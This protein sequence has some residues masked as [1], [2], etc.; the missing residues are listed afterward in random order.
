MSSVRDKVARMSDRRVAAPHPVQR[1][2]AKLTRRGRSDRGVM[3]AVRALTA[4]AI[5]SANLVGAAIVFVILVWVIPPDDQVG[6]AVVN[7]ILVAGYVLVAIPLGIVWAFRKLRPSRRWM[8]EDR[9]P[10][11]E[12]QLNL[13]QSPR[14]VFVVVVGSLWLLAALV[15]GVVNTFESFELGRRVVVAIVLAGLATCQIAYLLTEWLLRPLAA[16]ALAARPLEDPALPGVTARTLI[17]WGLGS[18]VP[19]VGL[20]FVGL[21]VLIDGDMSRDQLAMAVL[22]LTAIALL[23]GFVATLIAARV[24]ADPIISVAMPSQTSPEATLTR[25]FP[26]TTAASSAFCRA[27]STRWSRVCA[28]ASACATSSVATSVRTLLA[29]RSSARRA[30]EGRRVKWPFCSST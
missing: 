21:S 2:I 13:L 1:R 8:L 3:R 20:V 19:M 12:E 15:F 22:A 4:L 18:G 7:L 29:K 28:S 24:T 5:S 23:I 9:A 26:S 10:T 14:I 11:Q 17:T 30:W 27:D 6:S 16:R 25:R